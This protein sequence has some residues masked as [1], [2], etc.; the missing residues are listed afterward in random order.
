[1]MNKNKS[2]VAIKRKKSG[3]SK[4]MQS[5]CEVNLMMTFLDFKNLIH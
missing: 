4:F 3:H 1:M 5:D 2:R